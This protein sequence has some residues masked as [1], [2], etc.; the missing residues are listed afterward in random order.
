[1]LESLPSLARELGKQPPQTLIHDNGVSIHTQAVDTL[2]NV[3]MHLYRNA[4][5]HGIETAQ[6]RIANGKS[7]TGTIALTVSV[8]G[9]E[10]VLR[11]RDDGRGLALNFI[12]KKAV[13]RGLIAASDVLTDARI[14][15]LI[16]SAGFSTADHVTEI[17][18]RGVGMDAVKGFVQQLGGSLELSF[19]DAPLDGYR[20]FE[21]VIRLPAQLAVTPILRLLQHV[22]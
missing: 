14:G 19:E 4:L 13:E 7:P 8:Q 10:L 1:M 9:D 18:G 5:D 11:L 6:Q 17:S 12:Y 20:P 2:K 3:C 22:A 15:Q 16:F 21:T